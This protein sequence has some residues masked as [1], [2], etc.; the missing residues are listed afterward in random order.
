MKSE[1]PFDKVKIRIS[2]HDDNQPAEFFTNNIQ[3]K[4]YD[5]YYYLTNIYGKQSEVP[6]VE[7]YFLLEVKYKF[8]PL[9]YT[10]ANIELLVNDEIIKSIPVD[11]LSPFEILYIGN[12]IIEQVKNSP[13]QKIAAIF[14][15]FLFFLFIIDLI[16]RR[17]KRKNIPVCSTRARFSSLI[18]EN[19]LI[20]IEETNNPFGCRLGGMRKKIKIEYKRS[21]IYISISGKKFIFPDNEPVDVDVNEFW[22]L[23]VEAQNYFGANNQSHKNIVILLLPV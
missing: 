14:A 13:K 19:Q 20:K 15:A 9:K 1:T 6:I 22:K 2:I 18:E 11:F 5:K 16:F 4:K 21:Q 12:K 17:K 3:W 7:N 23:H 8:K 10:P